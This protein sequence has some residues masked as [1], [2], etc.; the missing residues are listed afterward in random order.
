MSIY[1]FV[2]TVDNKT[3]HQ[4]FFEAEE[5][6]AL[7]YTAY[8]EQAIREI[9]NWNKQQPLVVFSNYFTTEYNSIKKIDSEY[10]NGLEKKLMDLSE[11]RGKLIHSFHALK[12]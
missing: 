2:I 12:D 7:K 5:Q 9:V 1:C 8:K 4:E 10:V 3:Y 11:L 6:D